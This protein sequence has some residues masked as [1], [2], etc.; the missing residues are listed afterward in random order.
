MQKLFLK[1][2]ADAKKGS[3]VQAKKSMFGALVDDAVANKNKL[4]GLDS[5]IPPLPAAL[6]Q[7]KN[8][9]SQS[10]T[11]YHQS[12]GALIILNIASVILESIPI[13]KETVGHSVWQG[14]ETLSVFIFS[15]EYILNVMTSSYDAKWG[16]SRYSFCTSFQGLADFFAI[17]P[18]YLI[19]RTPAML[20]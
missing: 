5:T 4:K 2:K 20:V 11:L 7:W 19:C 13:V 8:T 14:F 1:N 17:L 16:F 10:S 15:G 18:Y 3:G 6:C 9:K 12:I